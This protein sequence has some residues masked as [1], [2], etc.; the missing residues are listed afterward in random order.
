MRIIMDWIREVSLGFKS[1]LE[2]NIR[3][4]ARST[5]NAR[6]RILPIFK[7]PLWAYIRS[8]ILLLLYPLRM[9]LC[10]LSYRHLAF[11]YIVRT[12]PFDSCL[13]H[14]LLLPSVW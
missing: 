9:F 3:S 10:G 6:V 8:S 12:A 2:K 13:K 5:N 4:L 7:H 1:T 11:D 14:I